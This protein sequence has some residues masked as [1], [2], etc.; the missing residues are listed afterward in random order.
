MYKFFDEIYHADESIPYYN[1][2][3]TGEYIIEALISLNTAASVIEDVY[4]QNDAESYDK[5]ISNK[6][7][8]AIKKLLKNA[9]SRVDSIGELN[10]DD[11]FSDTLHE[12]YELLDTLYEEIEADSDLNYLVDFDYADMQDLETEEFENRYE[13]WVSERDNSII[14]EFNEAYN[15]FV[16][17]EYPER[18]LEVFFKLKS[19]HK[20]IGMNL[21]FEDKINNSGESIEKI[22]EE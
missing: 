10:E 20:Q 11:I 3:E 1:D 21:N 4:D 7:V 18:I 9:L 17:K 13:D 12:V 6:S 15:G 16:E 19:I 8:K 2:A 5:L 14:N 22:F